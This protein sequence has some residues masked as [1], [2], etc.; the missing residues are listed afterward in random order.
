MLFTWFHHE[1]VSDHMPRSAYWV[2]VRCS[3]C[4]FEGRLEASHM[5]SL[6]GICFNLSANLAFCV[7]GEAGSFQ[8]QS[9][10]NH[11]VS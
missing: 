10:L 7:N 5:Y 3:E 4:A 8:S 9:V 1:I 6:Y 11:T 2:F